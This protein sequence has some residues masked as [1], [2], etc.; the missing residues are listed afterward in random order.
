MSVLHLHY[1][2]AM[3]CTICESVAKIKVQCENKSSVYASH[4]STESTEW[5]LGTQIEHHNKQNVPLD[6]VY[7][8]SSIYRVLEPEK[9]GEKKE[10]MT[11]PGWFTHLKNHQFSKHQDKGRGCFCL[12]SCCLRGVMKSLRK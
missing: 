1:N 9:V 3:L 2:A 7:N 10:F 5:M 11:S 8:S 4:T 6:L 12:L